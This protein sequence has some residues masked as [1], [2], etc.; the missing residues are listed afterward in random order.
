MNLRAL[1]DLSP[2][3]VITGMVVNIRSKATMDGYVPNSDAMHNA[4]ITVHHCGKLPGSTVGTIP[5]WFSNRQ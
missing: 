1:K 4:S 5:G 2:V 3:A